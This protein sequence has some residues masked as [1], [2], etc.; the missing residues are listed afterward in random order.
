MDSKNTNYS[1]DYIMKMRKQAASRS[2]AAHSAASKVFESNQ[3]MNRVSDGLSVT[4]SDREC[5]IVNVKPGVQELAQVL[6]RNSSDALNIQLHEINSSVIYP[7]IGDST[8]EQCLAVRLAKL[9]P[10]PLG[11]TPH[12]L[13]L[14]PHPLGLTPQPLGLTTLPPGIYRDPSETYFKTSNYLINED[15]EDSNFCRI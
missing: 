6:Y 13:G 12:P 4:R 9:T 15:D 2:A 3:V 1:P 14:T 7:R 8:I 10:Q 5:L 11:L